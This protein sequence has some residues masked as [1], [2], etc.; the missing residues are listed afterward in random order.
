MYVHWVKFPVQNELYDLQA[1]SLE[2]RNVA[3]DPGRAAVRLDFAT[4]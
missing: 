1:D 4:A 3:Q 2:Q